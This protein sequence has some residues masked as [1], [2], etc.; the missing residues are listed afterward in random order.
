MPGC[1]CLRGQE[2]SPRLAKVV[3]KLQISGKTPVTQKAM[4]RPATC[5]QHGRQ[6][7]PDNADSPRKRACLE[8]GY[9]GFF[10]VLLLRFLVVEFQ[11]KMN[12]K[13]VKSLIKVGESQ[14]KLAKVEQ[15][16]QAL[17]Q[18]F[19]E[20]PAN[21]EIN[22]AYAQH[23]SVPLQCTYFNGDSLPAAGDRGEP[24]GAG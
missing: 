12:Q 11:Q 1:L 20:M 9:I 8:Q 7:F 21:A 6:T 24:R 18:A 10:L 16:V 15:H 4:Q 17:G 23:S 19:P 13:S 5:L 14:G 22:D 3:Q 2:S